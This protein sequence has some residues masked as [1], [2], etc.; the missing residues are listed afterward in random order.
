MANK[1]EDCLQDLRYS[2]IYIYIPKRKCWFLATKTHSTI[3]CREKEEQKSR[4][5]QL[6]TTVS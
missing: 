6:Q 5:I 1:V 4:R 3:T 2:I